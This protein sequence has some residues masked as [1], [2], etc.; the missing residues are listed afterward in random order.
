MAQRHATRTCH[1]CGLKAP[2]PDMNRAEI[3]VETGRSKSSVSGGTLIGAALGHK[4][5]MRSVSR[6]VFNTGQRTYMRKKQIWV[7]GGADC[8]REARAA[9]RQS[10]KNEGMPLWLGL[11]IGAFILF[12]ILGGGQTP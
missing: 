11:A 2:Q 4:S 5:S 1:F 12:F 6:S 10:K 8:A 9:A 7:C 3:Y